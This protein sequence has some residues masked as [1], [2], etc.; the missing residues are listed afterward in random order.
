MVLIYINHSFIIQDFE[1]GRK[2]EE[3]HMKTSFLLKDKESLHVKVS[4]NL[5]DTVTSQPT[6]HILSTPRHLK[7]TLLTEF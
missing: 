6:L 3:L 7:E 1:N 4:T 5:G 2:I